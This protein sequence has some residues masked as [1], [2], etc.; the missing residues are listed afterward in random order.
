MLAGESVKDPARRAERLWRHPYKWRLAKPWSMS[1][2]RLAQ[3]L[4][5]GSLGRPGAASR[6]SKTNWKLRLAIP[7]TQFPP[8]HCVRSC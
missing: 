2:R 5:G 6:T 3:D 7:S 8:L 4:W 1:E